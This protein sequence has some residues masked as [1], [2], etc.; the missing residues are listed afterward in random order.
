MPLFEAHFTPCVEI[1]WRLAHEYW[2]R[3]YATEAAR[4]A[5]DFGFHRLE[6][7][8][9]VSFTV[10]ANRRSRSVMERIGMTHSPNDDFEHPLLPHGH[11]L[12]HHVIY[13]MARVHD[14]A[15]LPTPMVEGCS[16]TVPEKHR[17]PLDPPRLSSYIL[18]LVSPPCVSA[19]NR[20]SK[21]PPPSRSGPRSR[22]MVVGS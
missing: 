22:S 18:R 3:G 15:E 17:V 13:R 21:F 9:I 14:P 1:G 20:E 2:G 6:L 8:E 11:P 12:R 5:L 7:K 19:S 10:P 16:A 4:A